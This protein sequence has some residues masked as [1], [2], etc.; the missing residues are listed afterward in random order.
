MQNS[1]IIIKGMRESELVVHFFQ[2][3][4]QSNNIS[5]LVDSHRHIKSGLGRSDH[6]VTLTEVLF[7]NQ[8]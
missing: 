5:L 8:S 2:A 6:L 4:I 1:E 7:F 3:V